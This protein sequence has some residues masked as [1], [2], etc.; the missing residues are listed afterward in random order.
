MAEFKDLIA[1]FCE[2]DF[3]DNMLCSSI[4][5]DQVTDILLDQCVFSF[6]SK[7]MGEKKKKKIWKLLQSKLTSQAEQDRALVSQYVD[8]GISIEEFFDRLPLKSKRFL[9]DVKK[10]VNE[11]QKERTFYIYYPVLVN[12][13]KNVQQPLLT[14]SCQLEEDS[15]QVNKICINK[16]ILS[17]IVAQFEGLEPAD[18]RL[19]REVDIN[20]V[21]IKI[22][23]I[24]PSDNFN[25]LCQVA[26]TEV[27]GV[28]KI[29]L[30]TFHGTADWTKSEKASVSFESP[31]NVRESCFQ[32]ELRSVEQFYRENHVLPKLVQQYFGLSQRNATNVDFANLSGFHLGSYQNKYPINRK[33]WKLLQVSD[34]ANFLCVEGP[35]GTGKTT[36]LK[37]IIADTLV[38]KADAL[39]DV[40]DEEWEEPDEESKGIYRSPLGGENR[41]SVIISSTNNKAIDNIGLELL[42][43]IPFFANFIESLPQNQGKHCKGSLCA[44]LGNS[45][46]IAAFFQEFFEPFCQYLD[47]CSIDPQEAKTVKDSYLQVR[48]RLDGL[49]NAISEFLA[50]QDQVGAFSSYAELEECQNRLTH[51][52]LALAKKKQEIEQRIITGKTTQDQIEAC[53]Q[54]TNQS[55]LQCQKMQEEQDGYLRT[56]VFDLH[57]YE[58]IRPIHKFFSFLMPRVNLLLKKYESAEQIRNMIQASN[59][60]Q[61][62]LS[63]QIQDARQRLNQISAQK[64]EAVKRLLEL[65]K[66]LGEINREQEKIAQKR[67]ALSQYQNLLHILEQELICSS[68]VVLGLDSYELRNAEPLVKLRKDAF[69]R[70]L[71]L[72]EAYICL[73][74]EPIK[75]NLELFL[76]Q[77]KTENGEFYN[78]CQLLYNGDR[79]YP[80]QRAELV[81]TLWETFFLCF[82][83]VTTTLHSFRKSTFQLIPNLFD[84]LLV[85]ESGQIVPYYLVAPLYR[86]RRT[87]IVGDVNQIEPIKNVPP[88][89][90]D[91]K[92][93][94]IMGEET[95]HRFCLD[96]ASA[97]DFAVAASEYYE[98]V[99]GKDCGV[100]LNEHRRC[101]PAIMSFSNQNIYHNVLELIG[102][103][104][105]D[106]LFGTNLVAFD[107]RG[108]KANQ[109]YNQAEID[110]CKEIVEQFIKRYG[111]EV[112]KDIGIITPF[113]RQSQELSKAIPEVEVGTTHVFQ[114]AE[115]KYILFSSVI[116]DTSTPSGLNQF[117]GQKGNLL[118]VAFSRAKKQFIFVGNL[119][120]AKESRNY[121]EKAVMAIRQNGKVFSLFDIDESDSVDQDVVRVLSGPQKVTGITPIDN[122]L[123]ETIPQG[124]IG[125]PKL[126]NEILNN[127]LHLSTKSVSIISPWIGSNV[128]TEGMLSEIEKKVQNGI[129]I[130]VTFGYRA[131]NCSL[132]PFR[133]AGV[134]KS[135]ESQRT[136][137]IR[138]ADIITVTEDKVLQFRNGNM[139]LLTF[140]GKQFLACRSMLQSVFQRS[141][142]G[143]TKWD[144]PYLAAIPF[145]GEKAGFQ[146]VSGSRRVDS[147]TFM[148]AQAGIP[149]HFQAA[150]IVKML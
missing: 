109:H 71:Q 14:F 146:S 148:D 30:Q 103:N 140:R 23:N 49:N 28:F 26:C 48:E 58:K 92:Y 123:R 27:N 68:D 53:I 106:K 102:S 19:L 7:I 89:L 61:A 77:R 144:L 75:N 99:D 4:K 115:K 124:I 9:D 36:L 81:R 100:I 98:V 96:F 104:D 139:D 51:D 55:I 141:S 70:A 133:R 132:I 41:Y 11:I 149:G 83:V 22:D 95:Y 38:K 8:G 3:L 121:L 134:A 135:V 87:V 119:Q 79:P 63:A 67:E 6:L 18:V 16:D 12:H 33:Q 107:I 60:Q 52:S 65:N 86:A 84:V 24:H 116:D 39:L 127:L 110:A 35:P 44:R 111:P 64:A 105:L 59:E 54:Q 82:P 91:E 108:V 13:R 42:M 138:V 46:N 130:R 69:D 1:Y 50:A 118:N 57:Q 88:Y 150:K 74:Q 15:F 32:A 147:H 40:W 93:V 25:Q 113:K 56:L 20:R 117:V 73:H 47:A 29:D 78:W 125:L 85:D 10:A 80:P 145:D 66:T 43:E 128:V 31:D 5:D 142:C 136:M 97:Q 94:Q 122:Y 137:G 17:L 120:S 131:K 2:Y 126:H 90:L 112:K 37:E 143:F 45:E 101:E 34:K 76:I 72:F 129:S 21:A 62:V 114:G